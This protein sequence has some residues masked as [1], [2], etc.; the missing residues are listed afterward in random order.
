MAGSQVA[1]CLHQ[2]K[3]PPLRNHV[4]DNILNYRQKAQQ[5]K[6]N[7]MRRAQQEDKKPFKLREFQNVGSRVYNAG[8]ASQKGKTTETPSV[9]GSRDKAMDAYLKNLD[10]E[11]RS[12][13]QG[14]SCNGQEDV[15]PVVLHAQNDSGE[16]M[17]SHFSGGVMKTDNQPEADCNVMDGSRFCL[18]P[19][20]HAIMCQY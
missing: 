16:R 8:S 6:A 9:L 14:N 19:A 2:E 18:K 7:S 13:E 11:N 5:Q 20:Q 4:K 3:R 17:G 1:S 12:A 10:K 15:N